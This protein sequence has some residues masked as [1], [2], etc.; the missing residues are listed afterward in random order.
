VLPDGTLRVAATGPAAPGADVW[1]VSLV[2]ADGT[3]TD[4]GEHPSAEY[5]DFLAD[6]PLPQHTASIAG[7]RVMVERE[8]AKPG[9]ACLPEG[10]ARP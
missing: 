10:S 7:A 3:R 8:G 6:L 2:R 5:G 1:R 4:L 9:F